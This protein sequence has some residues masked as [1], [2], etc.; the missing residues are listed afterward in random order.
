MHIQQKDKDQQGT[1]EE[2]DGNSVKEKA[3]VMLVIF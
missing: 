3:K 1:R 2:K